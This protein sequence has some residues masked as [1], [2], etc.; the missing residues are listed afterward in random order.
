[1]NKNKKKQNTVRAG[2]MLPLGT[3]LG[4]PAPS[5]GGMGTISNQPALRRGPAHQAQSNPV[6]SGSGPRPEGSES[7]LP[8][9]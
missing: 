6:V 8:V 5:A 3:A 4:S 9:S 7:P 1:M 2:A